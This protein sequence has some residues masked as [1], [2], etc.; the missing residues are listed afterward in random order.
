[1]QV[2]QFYQVSNKIM[3]CV[4]LDLVSYHMREEQMIEL[5]GQPDKVNNSSSISLYFVI[6]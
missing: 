2:D 3:P 5:P 4:F 6:K 1:M